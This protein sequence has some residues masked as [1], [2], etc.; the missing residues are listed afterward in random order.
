MSKKTETAKAVKDARGT[1]T[2]RP[3]DTQRAT[4]ILIRPTTAKAIADGWT[5]AL[6][7]RNGRT[8]F[9]EMQLEAFLRGAGGASVR[10]ELGEKDEKE[11]AKVVA[12]DI[13]KVTAR[14][15]DLPHLLAAGWEICANVGF[16]PCRL[17]ALC[18]AGAKAKCA[19]IDSAREKMGGLKSALKTAQSA[20]I[21]ATMAGK[22]TDKLRS[23]MT[24]AAKAI[25]DYE[26][27]YSRIEKDYKKTAR[28]AVA[29]IASMAD[30]R[31]GYEAN[32]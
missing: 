31:K 5:L 30:L 27:E 14:V 26:E 10:S 7:D 24:N 12:D 18:G 21:E 4:L 3:N 28:A 25:K 13:R 15:K 2:E 8:L 22:K 9:G 32:A 11:A 17:L 29:V 19:D 20:F 16:R 1:I 6:E 23:E